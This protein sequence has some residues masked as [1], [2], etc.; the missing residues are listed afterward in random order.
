[1]NIR[2]KEGKSSEGLSVRDIPR[3]RERVNKQGE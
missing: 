1:M 3:E 2:K